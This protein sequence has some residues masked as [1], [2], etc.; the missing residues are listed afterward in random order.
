MNAGIFFIIMHRK[1]LWCNLPALEEA[2]VEA[3]L[4]ANLAI[5]FNLLAPELFF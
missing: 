1:P 2:K 3:I 4:N 5:Y